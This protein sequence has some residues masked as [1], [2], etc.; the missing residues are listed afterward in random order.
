MGEA[1]EQYHDF[2]GGEKQVIPYFLP[3]EI[4]P[5]LENGK[6][7]FLANLD[8]CQVL[9]RECRTIEDARK[10]EFVANVYR[11][12]AIMV[13][14]TVET[15]NLCTSLQVKVE[16]TLG[17]ILAQ[18]PKAKGAAGGGKKDSP[19]GIYLEPRDSTP[20]IA[21]LGISK[22][23][24]SQCRRLA[25]QSEASI[26]ACVAEA[27]EKG[28]QI[29]TSKIIFKVTEEAKTEKRNAFRKEAA[30]GFTVNENIMVGDF[31]DH[32][33]SIPDGS[34]SL[35]FTDPPYDSKASQ[36][37]LVDLGKFAEAKLAEGG[38][39]LCYVGQLQLPAAFEAFPEHLRYWWTICC[40]YAGHSSEMRFHGIH[41][42]WKAV[43]W[44]VKGTRDE[45]TIMVNDVMSG[46]QEKSHHDWQQSLQEAEYWIEKLCP[47][48]GI[49]CDPFLGSGTTAVAAK[50]LKRKWIGIEIDTETAKIASGRILG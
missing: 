24:S 27:T 23:T 36:D 31:R 50:R 20:T 5:A 48:D 8:K 40:L 18:T 6:D 47:I 42:R 14:S 46:G 49:V 11:R 30:A 13:K 45:R 26:D 1:A 32:S 2:S 38:S 7:L 44:F 37:V 41:A 43:L 21:E 15:V 25:K 10:F 12:Y 34:L 39:M 35:I 33:A 16:R 4:H 9:L 29:S 17:L 3:D 19:R 28:E 22:K